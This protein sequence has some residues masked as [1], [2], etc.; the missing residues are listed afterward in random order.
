MLEAIQ[1]PEAEGVKVNPTALCER[2]SSDSYSTLGEVPNDWRREQARAARPAISAVPGAL[3]HR[4]RHLRA[5]ARKVADA[6]HEP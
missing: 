6:S 2:P 5:E 4:L 3:A 1:Q